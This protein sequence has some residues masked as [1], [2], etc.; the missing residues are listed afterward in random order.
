MSDYSV[1]C[2]PDLFHPLLDYCRRHGL[3]V[4]CRW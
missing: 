1:L 3:S 4:S 2:I